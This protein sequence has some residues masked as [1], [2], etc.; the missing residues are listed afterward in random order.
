[1]QADPRSAC[2]VRHCIADPRCHSCA[3]RCRSHWRNRSTNSP[4]GLDISSPHCSLLSASAGAA[5][6]GDP[7]VFKN[8]RH[9]A[10]FLG[11]VPLQHSCYDRIAG[12]LG[13][14]CAPNRSR[15][16]N[17]SS[18]VSFTEE[19]DQLAI[20]RGARSSLRT[21]SRV[22]DKAT[23]SS[24]RSRSLDWNGGQPNLSCI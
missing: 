10:A 16:P 12:A 17:P 2:R 21:L 1:M 20:V 6:M 24:R 23:F 3:E 14:T 4:C 9:F 19:A 13:A 11:L 5:R 18:R 15:S 8:G 7:K 22:R